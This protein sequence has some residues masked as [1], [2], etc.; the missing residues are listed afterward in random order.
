MQ[1]VARIRT[2]GTEKK[3]G[4]GIKMAFKIGFSAERPES[5]SVEAAYS[6]ENHLPFQMW[7]KIIQRLK[8]AREA[9]IKNPYGQEFASYAESFNLYVL[10]KTDDEMLKLSNHDSN[11]VLFAHRFDIAQL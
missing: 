11:A 6:E 3:K 10:A 1:V 7:E 4:Q 5:K 9:V 2:C 8:S